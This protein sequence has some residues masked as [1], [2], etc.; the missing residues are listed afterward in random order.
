MIL[1][2]VSWMIF[3]GNRDTFSEATEKNW[4]VCGLEDMQRLKMLYIKVDNL[5]ENQF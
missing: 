4:L 3:G 2:N 1:K 5:V